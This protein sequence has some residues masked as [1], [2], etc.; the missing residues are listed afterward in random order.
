MTSTRS[1]FPTARATRNKVFDALDAK[2]AAVVL[3]NPN[4]FGVIDDHSDIVE[5]CH[6]MGIL[7]IQSVYPIA[8]AL[9]KSPGEI[10]ADI[11]TGEGQSLGFPL[12]F[13]G[14]YLGFMATSKKLVR[15]M[16]GRHGGAYS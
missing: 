2:T 3:Q 15:K 13:G 11:A 12:S 6:S 16:P 1:P 8:L 4:F 5:R 14:P 9:L 7:V 10:G